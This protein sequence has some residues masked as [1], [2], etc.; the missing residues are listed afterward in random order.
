MHQSSFTTTLDLSNLVPFSSVRYSQNT[1]KR[2]NP[3]RRRYRQ[4]TG[5]WGKIRCKSQKSLTI[6][7]EYSVYCD[8]LHF[9]NYWMTQMFV[10]H[11]ISMAFW[12][13]FSVNT[14]LSKQSYQTPSKDVGF[15]QI[16]KLFIIL[17][18]LLL[19][20]IIQP[21]MTEK[22]AYDCPLDVDIIL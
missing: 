2:N 15:Q 21:L 11:K 6:S 4:L 7:V 10:F 1:V 17:S 3:V 19:Y 16:S 20:V 14:F 12:S 13:I 5:N 9:I 8:I 18:L 22:L